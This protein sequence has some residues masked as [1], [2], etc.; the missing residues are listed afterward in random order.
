MKYHYKKGTIERDVM[1]I[2]M[3]YLMIAFM[4]WSAFLWIRVYVAEGR[5]QNNV[6]EVKHDN[7]NYR[8]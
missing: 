5:L 2:I 6:C 1:F 7:S 4:V 3:F 8:F